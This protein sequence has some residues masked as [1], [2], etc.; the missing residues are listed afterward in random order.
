MFKS[1][2]CKIF[3]LHKSHFNGFLLSNLCLFKSLDP[4]ILFSHKSHFNG[5]LQRNL[6]VFKSLDCENFFSH[7]SHLNAFLLKNSCF[8]LNNC[9]VRLPFYTCHIFL[10]SLHI[11]YVFFVLDQENASP[12]CSTFS[13]C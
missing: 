9:V 6:C 1:L 5:F 4:E 12:T 8:F 10:S 3:F 11:V 2:D 13:E 7:K